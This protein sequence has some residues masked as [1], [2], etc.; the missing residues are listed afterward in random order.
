MGFPILVRRHLY[1]N[2]VQIVSFHLPF[3]SSL[4]PITLN[5]SYN[6]VHSLNYPWYQTI[7]VQLSH[8]GSQKAALPFPLMS[9]CSTVPLLQIA[10]DS[11]PSLT[12]HQISQ[13][14][15]LAE[16]DCFWNFMYCQRGV[17]KSRKVS[18]VKFC[19]PFH[20]YC[21]ATYGEIM[22]GDQSCGNK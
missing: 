7:P 15:I 20:L 9:M 12:Y 19:V 14:R 13:I 18:A 17:K 21:L 6:H 4:S 11:H 5:R 1:K 8:L 2:G 16:K 10:W 22:F 3:R